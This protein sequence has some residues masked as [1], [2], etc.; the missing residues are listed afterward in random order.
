MPGK[1]RKNVVIAARDKNYHA[2]PVGHANFSAQTALAYAPVFY[3]PPKRRD[4]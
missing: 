3:L 2:A 4:A 1:Q